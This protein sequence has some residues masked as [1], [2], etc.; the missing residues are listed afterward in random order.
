MKQIPSFCIRSSASFALS[1]E[2]DND[3]P[4]PAKPDPASSLAANCPH[5]SKA[6]RYAVSCPASLIFSWRAIKLLGLLLFFG[7]LSLSAGGSNARP[8]NIVFILADD[9]GWTDLKSFGS[10]LYQTPNIDRLAQ[11][12]MR[13]NRAYSAC[14][15]CSPTR[16]SI[17]TGRYPAALHLT[18]WI[19]GHRLPFAKLNVPEWTM[20]LERRY[21]NLAEALH[22]SGYAT[23][24]FGKWHLGGTEDLWPE[25]QGFDLNVGGWSIGQPNGKNGANGYFSPYGNP[26]LSDGPKG[27]FLDDR[28]AREASAFM[29]RNRD[30]PFFVNFWF[31]LVHT[32]LQSEPE[33][34]AR[35]REPAAKAIHHRNPV[36]AAMIEHMDNAVGQL[37]A[38]L[39]RLGLRDNTIVVFTSDNGGLIGNQ[40]DRSLPPRVTSNFPLRT[41]KGDAYEGGVRVPLIVRF[42]PEVKPGVTSLTPVIS[43]D[44]Y[45]T[46]LDLAGIKPTTRT[47]LDF[48]GV[49]FSSIMRGQSPAQT[50][51]ALYWHYPH[52][53]TEGASPYGAILKGPW[54]LLEY[55]EDGR[56]ELYNLDHDIGEQNDLSKVEPAVRDELRREL[57]AWRE[58]EGAQMPSPNPKYD[59]KRAK[60]FQ[61]DA[62]L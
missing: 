14:T 44:F 11:E 10:D 2:R 60:Q 9:I 15:V 50:H 27:E 17:M 25:H 19:A 59:A 43:P 55:Y 21:Y 57:R 58:R 36:Y 56:T 42:P 38:T 26:R 28:L 61:I 23:A 54:K 1:G 13:F 53:H 8:P 32:P 33:L 62:A 45:P 29:E 35:Y 22:D 4:A 24:H 34:V 12:G 30:R 5:A 49:S 3:K 20:G 18:D 48:D 6:R 39:D 40:G 7:D 51:D 52:Y 16:A 46:L 31:Y 37:M 41:G 47:P